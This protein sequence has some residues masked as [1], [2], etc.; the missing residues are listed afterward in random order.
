MGAERA[1]EVA[2]RADAVVAVLAE[3]AALLFEA[4]S[5]AVAVAARDRH[6]PDHAVA[7]SQGCSVDGIRPAL[8]ERDDPADALVPEHQGNRRRA[9]PLHGVHVGAADRRE[10]DRHEHVVVFEGHARHRDGLVPLAVPQPHHGR[11]GRVQRD[12]T[13]RRARP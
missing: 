12:V 3:A 4:C 10:L 5:A 8:A 2:V 1:G 13:V 11:G 6:R 7:Q 9:P